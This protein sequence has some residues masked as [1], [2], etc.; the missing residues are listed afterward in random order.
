MLI[1]TI[2][3]LHLHYFLLFTANCGMCGLALHDVNATRVTLHH[4][5]EM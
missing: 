3:S 4:I 2:N 5:K 1:C